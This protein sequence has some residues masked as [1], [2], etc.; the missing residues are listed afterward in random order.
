MNSQKLIFS[1]IFF[2]FK[3]FL[4]ILI[5]ASKSVSI[6]EMDAFIPSEEIITV[7]LIFFFPKDFIIFFFFQI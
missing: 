7:P 5:V 1:E 6:P 4:I 2:I 3:I